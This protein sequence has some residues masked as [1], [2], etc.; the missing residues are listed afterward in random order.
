MGWA[1]CAAARG[2]GY[3][4]AMIFQLKH[5]WQTALLATIL[6]SLLAWLACGWQNITAGRLSLGQQI[7]V[8]LACGVFALAVDGVLHALFGWRL[9][10]EYQKSFRAHGA[11]VCGR[12]GPAE[13]FTGGLMAGLAEE[14]F[15]RGV[16]LQAILPF[17]NNQPMVAVGA[18]SLVFAACHW[19]S[20]RFFLF[21]CWAFW[22][23]ALFG[24]A[25]V[26]TESLLVPMIAHAVHDWVGY[27]MFRWWYC[28]HEVE[29]VSSSA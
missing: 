23:G 29:E 4:A 10:D 6:L 15:F 13:V 27:G 26:A 11:A 2:A 24:A 3:L 20:P 9:R 5:R 16:L 17:A 18:T 25:Y 22:E 28:L 21:W 19:I 12:M 8:G 14:P 7:F 1:S